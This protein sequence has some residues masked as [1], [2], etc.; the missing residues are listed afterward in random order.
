MESGF[1]AEREKTAQAPCLRLDPEARLCPLF[2]GTGIALFPTADRDRMG[3]RVVSDFCQ[4][5]IM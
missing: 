4:E 3:F 1:T 5:H 2:D